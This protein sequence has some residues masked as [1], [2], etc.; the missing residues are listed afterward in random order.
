MPAYVLAMV[1]VT[2]P[3]RYA[4]YA[5]RTPAAIAQFGGK[6]VIRGGPVETLEGAKESRRF[7]LIEFPTKEAARGFYDCAAYQEA[8]EIRKGAAKATFLLLEGWVPPEVDL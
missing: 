1:E 8:R 4:Q 2:D 3:Q 5:Q 7:V 6:F